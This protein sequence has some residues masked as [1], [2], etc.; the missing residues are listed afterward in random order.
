MFS[1]FAWLLKDNLKFDFFR[2]CFC[3]DRNNCLHVTSLYSSTSTV[4][5]LRT[6]VMELPK[7]QDCRADI[8][9]AAKIKILAPQKLAEDCLSDV[10]KLYS[11][12]CC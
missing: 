3:H 1:N 2:K 8:V 7:I 11:S 12:K 10:V 5:M 4:Q 9:R 6:L